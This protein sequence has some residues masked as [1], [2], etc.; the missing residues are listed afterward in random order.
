MTSMNSLQ[1]H[2][3]ATALTALC[4][5]VSGTQPVTANEHCFTMG[6]TQFTNAI[7]YCTSSVLPSQSANSYGPQNL[8][9]DDARTAWC[10][11]VSGPGIGE[12]IT[13]H[14]DGGS[15]FQRLQVSNGYGKSSK[16]YRQNNRLKLVEISTNLTRPTQVQLIDEHGYLPVPLTRSAEYDWVRIRILSVY[17][18]TSYDDTCID[19]IM[20]DFEYDEMLLQQS[21][22]G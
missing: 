3:L 2:S 14:I 18:G 1:N 6:A 16:S 9:D 10:E 13:L 7:E 17:P 4:V 19:F 22:E 5:F 15:S 12:T 20:P 21:Q 8:I 11:G